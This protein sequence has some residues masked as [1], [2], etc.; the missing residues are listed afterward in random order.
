MRTIY[1]APRNVD[2]VA[3]PG[4]PLRKIEVEILRQL[5]AGAYDGEIAR[6]LEISVRH[7]RR[8]L[9]AALRKLPARTRA[10]AVAIA[11]ARRIITPPHAHNLPSP[12]EET[13]S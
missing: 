7:Y 4:Q 11:L 8:Y 12:S 13:A 6:A 2:H 3:R 5:A 10:Q 9:T 1:I